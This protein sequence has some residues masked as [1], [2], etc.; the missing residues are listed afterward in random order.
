[1]YKEIVY[2]YLK[3]KNIKD[4]TDKDFKFQDDGQGIYIKEWNISEIIKPEIDIIINKYSLEV[5]KELKIKEIK[6][7]IHNFIQN[8]YGDYIQLNTL[9]LIGNLK[10][11]DKNDL[12][13]FINAVINK[14]QEM[15]NEL[16]LLDN[17]N[18]VKNFN[19]QINIL[20]DEEIL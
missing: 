10:Q 6:D 14:E 17:L 15:F 7:N 13:N 12:I 3:E 5:L 9:N 2:K 19:T 18:D 11:K 8:K 1:M 20:I 4:K 16:N